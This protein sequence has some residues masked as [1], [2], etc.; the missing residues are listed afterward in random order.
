MT[1]NTNNPINH[2]KVVSFGIYN[3]GLNIV[4]LHECFDERSN[5]LDEYLPDALDARLR[6]RVA[7][8]VVGQT[9][10]ALKQGH[11]F[12]SHLSTRNI[13]K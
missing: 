2:V 7:L 10:H 4:H 3:E 8:R 5:F 9:H 12:N 1:L 6:G 13:T 11:V